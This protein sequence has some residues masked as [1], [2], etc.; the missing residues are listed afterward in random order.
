MSTHLHPKS[1]DRSSP[2]SAFV[3]LA[4]TAP[5]MRNFIAVLGVLLPIYVI[6]SILLSDYSFF[7]L[8]FFNEATIKSMSDQIVSQNMS[9]VVVR[10][11]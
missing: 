2:K 7:I 3:I 1:L 10:G 8:G 6:L 4:W 11:R 5:G 9:K